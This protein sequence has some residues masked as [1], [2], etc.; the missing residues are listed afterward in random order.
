MINGVINP[1]LNLITSSIILLSILFTL[2][3]ISWLYSLTSGLVIFIVYLISLILTKRKLFKYGDNILN[4]R[5]KVIANIQEGIG[6]IRDIILDN[7]QKFYSDI[8]NNLDRKLRITQPKMFFL[9]A[10]PRSII[11]PTGIAVIAISGLILV[12]N[13]TIEEALPLIGVLAKNL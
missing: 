8:H 12:K 10:F 2:L 1:I 3:S 5:R 6:S 4:F 13:G 7:N 9:Q 11:E